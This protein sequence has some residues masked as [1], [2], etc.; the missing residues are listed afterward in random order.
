MVLTKLDGQQDKHPLCSLSFVPIHKKWPF[1]PLIG[2][3]IIKFSPATAELIL[4]IKSW[5]SKYIWMSFT[6]FVFCGPMHQQRWQVCPLICWYFFFSSA[7]AEWVSKKHIRK[8]VNVLYHLCFL[9]NLSTKKENGTVLTC[10][11]SNSLGSALLHWY[12]AFCKYCLSNACP[13][14]A[15]TNFKEA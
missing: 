7:T 12:K 3:H 6:K 13:L 11:I 10:T 15:P 4:N 9:A 14:P 2:R 1:W 5:K 8:Q